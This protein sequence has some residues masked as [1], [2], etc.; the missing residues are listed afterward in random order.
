MTSIFCSVID[1]EFWY[2]NCQSSCGPQTLRRCYDE[3][4]CQ[5]QG[6]R[7]KKWRQFFFF[8][9][10]FCVYKLSIYISL[11]SSSMTHRKNY[12]FMPLSA[13][14]QWKLTMSARYSKKKSNDN[15]NTYTF[16]D[17]LVCSIAVYF[18]ESK[19]I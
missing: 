10:F 19:Y 3:F 7:M 14:W 11:R 17:V 2:I 12:K 1:H 13:Y 15:Q 8:I 16:L 5:Q 4:H 6:R 9:F 18:Y